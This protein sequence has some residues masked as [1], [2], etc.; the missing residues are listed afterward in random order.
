MTGSQLME[1]GL[2]IDLPERPSA[3]MLFL[4]LEPTQRIKSDDRTPFCAIDLLLES[5]GQYPRYG[6]LYSHTPARYHE[7]GVYTTRATAI[8]ED[9]FVAGRYITAEQ[10][11]NATREKLE[12]KFDK[13]LASGPGSTLEGGRTTSNF[14][15]LDIEAPFH[16]R[17][18][19]TFA[20][21]E[22]R[23]IVEAFRLR[24]SVVKAK[25]PDS[26][27]GLWGT[28]VH[29]AAGGINISGYQRAAA[30]GVFEQV[31]VLVPVLYHSAKSFS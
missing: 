18:W 3:A 11:L 8:N 17:D 20:D 21:A 27:V 22:L 16:P 9:H 30:M 26:K 6:S 2:R 23:R 12:A 24:V 25:L 28:A 31:D 29:S 13:F 5:D 4:R 1:A 10:F 7:L 14:L 15:L 19:Y